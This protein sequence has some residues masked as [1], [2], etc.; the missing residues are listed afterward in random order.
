[1]KLLKSKNAS[2]G[3]RT[4]I[5]SVTGLNVNHCTNDAFRMNNLILNKET[6]KISHI[7]V[8]INNDQISDIKLGDKCVQKM[9]K[10]IISNKSSRILFHIP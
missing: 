1:M 4:Q 9:K 3:N 2:P 8:N 6:S 5:S 10:Q 7:R